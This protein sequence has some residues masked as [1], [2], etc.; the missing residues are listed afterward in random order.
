VAKENELEKGLGCFY[1]FGRN[2]LDV[3]FAVRI[4]LKMQVML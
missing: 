4:N 2:V 3:W 1:V